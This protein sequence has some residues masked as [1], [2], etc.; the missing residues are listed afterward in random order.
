M[1]NGSAPFGSHEPQPEPPEDDERMCEVCRGSGS[2]DETLGGE[3]NSDPNAPC[4]ECEGLGY[5]VK[6]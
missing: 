6:S 1:K 2:I 5:W 3:W 4:P